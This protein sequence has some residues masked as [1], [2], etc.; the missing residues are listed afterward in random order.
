MSAQ[1]NTRVL[2]SAL[3]TAALTLLAI[4]ALPSA[5]DAGGCMVC[6][7][8]QDCS[9]FGPDARC[10]LWDHDPGCGSG[11]RQICCPGQGCTVSGG[12]VMCSGCAPVDSP[13]A[14]SVDTG[15]PPIDSG[16]P[17]GDGGPVSDAGLRDVGTSTHADASSGGGGGR[18]AQHVDNGCQCSA[19]AT[20]TGS[21][22]VALLALALAAL[23][24]RRR[25]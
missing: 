10:V 16:L 17:P 1:M 20:A 7:T 18:G 8:S 6:A 21:S 23:T 4:T 11:M 13:D 9:P 14:G 3:C 15:L 2:T 12:Q 5:A 22:S 19:R 25:R 24:A